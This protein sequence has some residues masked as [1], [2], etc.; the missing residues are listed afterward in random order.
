MYCGKIAEHLQKLTKKVDDQSL[1]DFLEGIINLNYDDN[2]AVDS[3]IQR[4][5][6]SE[7]L[8]AL[9]QQLFLARD[10]LFKNIS[11]VKELKEMVEHMNGMNDMTPIQRLTCTPDSS[12]KT[13]LYVAASD[14]QFSRVKILLRL[15]AGKTPHSNNYSVT[16]LLV[17]NR[18]L[19]QHN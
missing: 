4:F 7:E 2:D 17:T 9:M 3:A 11:D 13:P 12:G 16:S 19:F 1:S 8:R 6:E 14:K 10:K 5:I 18:P 15:G